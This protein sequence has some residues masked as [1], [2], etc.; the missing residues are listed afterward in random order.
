[1]RFLTW[2][3]ALNTYVSRQLIMY[4]WNGNTEFW[5]GTSEHRHKSAKKAGPQALEIAV[6]IELPLYPK[7]VGIPSEI[8]HLVNIDP[9]LAKIIIHGIH[10]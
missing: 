7:K 5:M 3:N 6:M 9:Q 10:H 2:Q 8:V 4:A 1:M